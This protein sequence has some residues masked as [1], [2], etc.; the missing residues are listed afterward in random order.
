MLQSV[1][2]MFS[3][4]DPQQVIIV[5]AAVILLYLLFFTLRDILLRTHSALYQIVSVLIVAF[6]PVFGFFLY[7]LIRPART[8]KERELEGLV[9]SVVSGGGG[10]NANESF[11]L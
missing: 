6:L 3:S 10:M 7:L 4:Y 1:L 11:L 8:I 2:S 5:V 9:R